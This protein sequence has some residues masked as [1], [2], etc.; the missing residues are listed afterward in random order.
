M[1]NAWLGASHPEEPP[2]SRTALFEDRRRAVELRRRDA[3]ADLDEYLLEL[4]A[5]VS[6]A[7]TAF[8]E[9]RDTSLNRS[10]FL[11]I[12]RQAVSD[13]ARVLGLDKADQAQAGGPVNVTIFTP[14]AEDVRVAMETLGDRLT[15]PSLT[16]IDAPEVEEPREVRPALPAPK[17]KPPAPKAPRTVIENGV[18]VEDFEPDALPS[19]PAPGV[20]DGWGRGFGTLLGG[21]GGS[22]A[23][24]FADLGG[25]R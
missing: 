17:R 1:V 4:E 23:S 5:L 24:R 10:A 7:W 20:D 16:V 3:P 22:M 13:R 8:D 6:E 21:G 19:A 14:S 12:V 2:I 9:A 15:A 11:G 25:H 18:E